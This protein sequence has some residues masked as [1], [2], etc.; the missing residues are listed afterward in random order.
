M[1]TNCLLECQREVAVRRNG[2]IWF[3]RLRE[4]RDCRWSCEERDKKQTDDSLVSTVDFTKF[5][6]L[7][8]QLKI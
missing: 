4:V 3:D 6:T 5:G 7:K 1:Q 8:N 2:S